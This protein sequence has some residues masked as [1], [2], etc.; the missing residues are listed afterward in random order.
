MKAI[1]LVAVV[2]LAAVAATGCDRPASTAYINSGASTTPLMP[3]APGNNASGVSRD[4]GAVEL[5]GTQ[6][7]AS[8][9]DTAATTPPASPSVTSTTPDTASPAVAANPAAAPA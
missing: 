3:A 1:A 6:Q 2:G 7:P 5:P 9:A 4:S 8:T